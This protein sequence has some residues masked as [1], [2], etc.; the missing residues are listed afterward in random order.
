[1]DFE[2]N[3]PIEDAFAFP[4]LE[5]NLTNDLSATVSSDELDLESILSEDWDS[6]PDQEEHVMKADVCCI[7]ARTRPR[8]LWRMDLSKH[9]HLLA[10]NLLKLVSC[11][12]PT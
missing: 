10:Y 3:D 12:I 2:R 4:D 7:G 5:D 8:T 1:M 6:V 11:F 9:M